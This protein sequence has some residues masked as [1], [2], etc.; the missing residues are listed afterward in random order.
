M[1]IELLYAPDQSL[2][3]PDG[4]NFWPDV[5]AWTSQHACPIYLILSMPRLRFVPACTR[6][7]GAVHVISIESASASGDPLRIERG[8]MANDLHEYIRV[9]PADGAVVLRHGVSMREMRWPDPMSLFRDLIKQDVDVRSFMH[10]LPCRVEYVGQTAQPWRQ[11]NRI[12][13][14]HRA[15]EIRRV[16]AR[17][18]PHRQTWIILMNFD[19][20]ADRRIEFDA[21][22]SIAD[23]QAALAPQH[24]PPRHQM[25]NAIEAALIA[26]FDPPFNRTFRKTFP[27]R[28]HSSYCWFYRNQISSIGIAFSGARWGIQLHGYDQLPQL[29]HARS[30]RLNRSPHQPFIADHSP[31]THAELQSLAYHC[32]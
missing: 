19:A 9:D 32:G 12:S 27:S 5:T 31:L 28:R 26:Q 2:L 25:I 10:L 22:D 17:Q 3:M 23:L 20:S 6:S 7:Y 14:H 15:P 24:K 1:N 16:L 18:E 13:R 11:R 29:A 8:L 21:G 30:F 4:L